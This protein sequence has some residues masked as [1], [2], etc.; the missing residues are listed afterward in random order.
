MLEREFQAKL[1]RKLGDMFP[2]C[3]ILK[4]DPN[5]IQG[6]PDLLIL[7]KDRWAALEVKQSIQSHY[8]P[9]QQYYLKI[10]SEMSFASPIYP[11]NEE[12]VLYSLCMYFGVV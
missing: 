4:N 9:N 6:F 8:Q 10:L 7:Y 11:E 5:Y 1:I 12:A 3:Y 2:G